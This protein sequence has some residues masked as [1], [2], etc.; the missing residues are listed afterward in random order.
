MSVRLGVLG[1]ADIALRRILPSAAGLPGVRITAIASRQRGKAEKAAATFG[2]DAVEGYQ[3]LL[4]RDDVDAVYIPLPP[5]L[6]AEWVRRALAAGKH[7]LAEKPLT[8]SLEDSAAAVDQAARAGLVLRENYM[9]VHHAQHGK[10]RALLDEGAIGDLRGLSAAFSIPRRPGT[11]F[12]YAASLGGGALLD[13]GGY[14][15]RLASH[16]LGPLRVVGA[17]RQHDVG[18]GVDISGDALLRRDDGV[19][20]HL[21]FGLDHAYVARYEVVGTTGR[22]TVDRAYSPPADLTPMIALHRAGGVETVALDPDDQCANTLTAFVEDVRANV[23]TTDEAIVTQA[24]LLDEIR[25]GQLST[26]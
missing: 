13:V 2:C 8:T 10:V 19:A 9:F 20:A 15:L 3:R 4:D 1:C 26:S 17:S 5:G 14:P 23:A 6:H 7:V 24:R 16:L 22:I 11:D 18:L 21:S 25:A 12:R